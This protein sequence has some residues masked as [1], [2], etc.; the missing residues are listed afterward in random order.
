MGLVFDKEAAD[1]YR[2]WQKSRQGRAISS[3]MDSFISHLLEPR[4]GDRILDIGCGFGDNLQFLRSR[5]AVATGLDPSPHMLAVAAGRIGKSCTLVKGTAEDL[6]FEDNEFDSAMLINTLEFLDD[7]EPAIREAARVSSRKTVL[8]SINKWSFGG[9]GNRLRALL[10]NRLFPRAEFYS[11]WKLR[12]LI[13]KTCGPVSLSWA[14]ISGPLPGG[15]E[16][17]FGIKEGIGRR[18]FSVIVGVSA[19]LAYTLRT[20]PL[21]IPVRLN[22]ALKKPLYTG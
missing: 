19:G 14:G 15:M 6:P 16:R 18:P 5:H 7:P 10:G 11:L 4:P 17:F 22:S 12:S 3:A 2:T 9:A 8:A 13:L 1:I 21:T 20:D